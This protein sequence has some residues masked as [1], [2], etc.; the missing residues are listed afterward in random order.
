[1][2]HCFT[3]KIC[4]MPRNYEVISHRN[5]LVKLSSHSLFFLARPTRIATLKHVL[6]PSFTFNLD[7]VQGLFTKLFFDDWGGRGGGIEFKSLVKLQEIFAAISRRF[8]CVFGP[9]HTEI[10]KLL[11]PRNR[12]HIPLQNQWKN[13]KQS[14]LC[15]Q[16]LNLQSIVKLA[17][18]CP[19]IAREN[20][21][22]LRDSEILLKWLLNHIRTSNETCRTKVEKWLF[23]SWGKKGSSQTKSCCCCRSLLGSGCPFF[24]YLI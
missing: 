8:D 12:S 4:L 2:R 13:R 19:N 7:Q 15:V 9:R 17:W 21:S 20:T 11:I 14:K 22:S 5:L 16:I 24:Y 23:T 6:L 3:N 1:V 10:L 18:I